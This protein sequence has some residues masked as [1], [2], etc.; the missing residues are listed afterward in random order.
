LQ[1]TLDLVAKGGGIFAGG[2]N[3]NRGLTIK[4]QSM[5]VEPREFDA[6]FS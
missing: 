2:Y 1:L 3:S 5:L 4:R 6:I